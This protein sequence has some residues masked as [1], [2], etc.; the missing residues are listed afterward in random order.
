MRRQRTGEARSAEPREW[1]EE[2]LSQELAQQGVQ[3]VEP[4]SQTTR[5]TAG[6]TGSP[7]GAGTPRRRKCGWKTRRRRIRGAG[8]RTSRMAAGRSTSPFACDIAHT[9]L[10][11]QHACY[12]GV[13][14]E[15]YALLVRADAA[16]VSAPPPPSISRAQLR[17]MSLCVDGGVV[18]VCAWGGGRKKGP[19]IRR[20]RIGCV[21]GSALRPKAAAEFTTSI[22]P[23]A[24]YIHKC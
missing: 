24:C 18:L 21:S 22:Y 7:A 9:W 4:A 11:G 5:E 16:D 17:A 1:Q 6:D 23:T 19:K 14:T 10:G 12:R 2:S 15:T 3:R 8:A 20:A 13:K